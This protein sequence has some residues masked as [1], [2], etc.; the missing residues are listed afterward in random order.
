MNKK[1][2]FIILLLTCR[3]CTA[4]NLVPNGDFESYINCPSN[5]SQFDSALFWFN[6]TYGTP[7]YFNQCSNP[8]NVGI[9]NNIFGY[10]PTLSGVGYTGIYLWQNSSVIYREYIEVPLLSPL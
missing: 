2:I 7:D 5:V 6:P 4:Q 10:Q 1:I 8:S 3:I 9:P